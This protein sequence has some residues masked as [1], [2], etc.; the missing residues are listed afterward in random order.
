MRMDAEVRPCNGV[1]THRMADGV[2]IITI[3]VNSKPRKRT[4]LHQTTNEKGR[5]DKGNEKGRKRRKGRIADR[6]DEWLD[7]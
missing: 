5:K 7:V 3:V 4:I 6:I 1:E 2:N